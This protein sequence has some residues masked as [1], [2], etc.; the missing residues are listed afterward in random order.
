MNKIISV[1]IGGILFQI[2]EEAYEI[3]SGYLKSVKL[4]FKNTAGSEEI[5][6]DIEGR[7]AEMLQ[8]RLKD[9]KG[10]VIPADVNNVI[11]RMGRPEDFDSYGAETEKEAE[12]GSSRHYENRRSYRRI[13]RDDEDKVVGGVC[14]GIAA[15]L[16]MD[17]L[18]LRLAFA[19][20]FFV[21]GSGL[22]LYIILWAIIPKA[23]TITD[24]LEMRGEPVNISNIKKNIQ[25]E[26]DELETKFEGY[27]DDFRRNDGFGKI[28]RAVSSKVPAIESFIRELFHVL[29]RIIGAMLVMAGLAV[30]IVFTLGY[31]GFFGQDIDVPFK[32]VFPFLFEESW[33]N[34]L[35]ILSL[36]VVVLIPLIGLVLAGIRLLLNLKR[37]PR[38]IRHTLNLTWALGFCAALVMILMLV[39]KFSD[40]ATAKVKKYIPTDGSRALMLEMKATRDEDMVHFG[41]RID[42]FGRHSARGHD[43]SRLFLDNVKLDIVHTKEPVTELVVMTFAH[44]SN[45][46]EALMNTS[47]IVYQYSFEDSVIRFDRNSFIPRN[48]PWRNQ[49]VKLLLKVPS[50]QKIMIGKGM[51][52]ILHDVN[53]E[54]DLYDRQMVDHCWIMGE[55]SLKCLDCTGHEKESAYMNEIPLHYTGFSEIE[56]R[57]NVRL[58]IQQGPSFKVAIAGYRD[59]SDDVTFDVSGNRL[60]IKSD[61]TWLNLDSD[62]DMP[63]VIVTLPRLEMLKLR[64]RTIVQLSEISGSELTI[65]STGYC[66]MKADMLLQQLNLELSGAG[67][68]Q[69]KGHA[70]EMNVEISGA[71][72]LNAGTF[73]TE[74]VDIEMTGASKAR[75]NASAHIKADLAGA[76]K[77]LYK[78]TAQVSS[79]ATGASSIEKE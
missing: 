28:R 34:T 13:F 2:D 40:S 22:L 30:M 72:E 37:F 10:V 15:Y 42:F 16:D 35:L 59:M 4:H 74:K 36:I 61:H 52:Y 32:G 76:S 53:N 68:V 12:A 69:L 7:I 31:T 29:G 21:F 26:I 70:G 45:Y 49:Q 47:G 18:W 33:M 75:I 3:L 43:S 38:E 17:P 55:T 14:S 63:T 64:D 23:R 44:G 77:L 46:D 5:V 56:S 66:E 54:Q 20:S 6:A 58:R 1:N 48:K 50:G 60:L 8:Q 41:D 67:K 57:G 65:T 62:D 71:G 24:R 78:G 19:V 25:E 79:S 27:R 51:E 9:S 39:S 11:D 73:E